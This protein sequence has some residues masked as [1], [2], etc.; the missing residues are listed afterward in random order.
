MMWDELELCYIDPN[1]I[2]IIDEAD[3]I[4][5]KDVVSIEQHDFKNEDGENRSKFMLNKRT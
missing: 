3:A 4:I 1:S 5:L 2:G